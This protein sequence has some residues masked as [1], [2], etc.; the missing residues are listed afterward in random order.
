MLSF[1]ASPGKSRN[2]TNLSCDLKP[3][4]TWSPDIDRYKYE[5]V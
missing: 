1:L 2:M 5:A 3:E 4:I